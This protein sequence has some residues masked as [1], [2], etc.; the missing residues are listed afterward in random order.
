M[1]LHKITN[2]RPIQ[3]LET[4]FLYHMDF[5]LHNERSK[6]NDGSKSKLLAKQPNHCMKSNSHQA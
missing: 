3:D 6:A 4:F 5:P 2:N 1:Q